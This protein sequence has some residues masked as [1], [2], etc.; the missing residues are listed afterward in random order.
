MSTTRPRQRN[1]SRATGARPRRTL[2]TNVARPHPASA[3]PRVAAFQRFIGEVFRLNGQ[4]LATADALAQDIGI[5]PAR[6]QTIAVIRD[7]AMT[8][9]DIA[10]RLGLRRQSVQHNVN[11]L[12]AQGLA[13][14]VPNPA[15]RRASLVRLTAAGQATMDVLYGL[16]AVLTAQ[17]IGNLGLTAADIEELTGSL[18]AMREAA[19]SVGGHGQ[20]GC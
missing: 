17:F 10:R 7:Q 18:R 16:Q 6:W 8:V 15:H 1:T 11:R 12:L 3:D 13:E 5:S 14:L 9:P 4:L 19:R 20:P 2:R